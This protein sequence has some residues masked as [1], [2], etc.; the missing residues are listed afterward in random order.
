MPFLIACG[1]VISW[2]VIL[3]LLGRFGE[4]DVFWFWV[5]EAISIPCSLAGLIFGWAASLDWSK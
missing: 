4:I 1:I 2:Q 3:G 5:V